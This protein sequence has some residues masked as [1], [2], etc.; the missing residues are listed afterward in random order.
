MTLCKHI[1]R[2]LSTF[3]VPFLVGWKIVSKFGEVRWNKTVAHQWSRCTS[4]GGWNLAWHVLVGGYLSSP[5]N[6]PFSPNKKKENF[7]S[8]HRS[9]HATIFFLWNTTHTITSRSSSSRG[10]RC[11]NHVFFFTAVLF[12]SFWQRAYCPLIFPRGS[13]SCRHRGRGR[14]WT[15]PAPRQPASSAW[16]RKA[17]VLGRQGR[18][19]GDPSA[20][21]TLFSWTASWFGKS[22]TW[23]PA[24]TGEEGRCTAP[25][26]SS[27]APSGSA[28]ALC[29]CGW[30]LSARL[31]RP[32]PRWTFLCFL[33]KTTQFRALLSA[34]PSRTQSAWNQRN[35]YTYI[36]ILFSLHWLRVTGYTFKNLIINNILIRCTCITLEKKVC[37]SR[38]CWS[39]ANITEDYSKSLSSVINERSNVISKCDFHALQTVNV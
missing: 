19:S 17:P 8:C 22:C 28:C 1:T 2:G 13:A 14:R 18:G 25:R 16:S 15:S 34:V 37:K 35:K 9:V 5:W 32:L 24:G 30:W 31:G 36:S 23:R 27:D 20:D 29:S 7:S 6:M 10:S 12:Y 38:V 33:S 3:F 4:R 11:I 39:W 21:G 26:R